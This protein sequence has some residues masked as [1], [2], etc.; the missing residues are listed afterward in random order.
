MADPERAAWLRSASRDWLSCDLSPRQ[1]CDLE[2]LLTGGFSPLTGFM[3]RTEHETVC[4]SMRLGTGQPWPWP[5]T[6]DVPATLGARLVPGA[7]LALRDPEDVMLAALHVEDVWT[8]DLEEESR[9]LRGGAERTGKAPAGSDVRHATHVGGRIEGL[10]LPAHYDYVELRRR[11]SD[12][13]AELAGRGWTGVAGCQPAGAMH[14]ADVASTCL[15]AADPDNGNGHVMVQL[16]TEG[17]APA[18]PRHHSMVRCLMAAVAAYPPG[19]ALLTIVPFA[20]REAGPREALLRAIVARNYGAATLL[21]DETAVDAIDA[22]PS[23]LPAGQSFEHEA[24]AIGVR[25]VRLPAMRYDVAR[26]SHVASPGAD[27]GPKVEASELA[28]RLDAGLPLPDWFTYPAVAA[29]L[30][31]LH[32]PRVRQGFTVFFTGLSGSGKSTIANV[33]LVRL[34]QAGGDRRA[35]LLDGDVV[36]HHLSSELGFSKAHRDL[37]VRR[38]GYVASEITKAGG[39]AICAPIAPYDAPRRDVRQMIAPLGGFVLVHVATPLDVC[40][41][42]DRKGLYTKARAGLLTHFTGI[43]DPYEAPA[44]ADVVIDTRVLSALEAADAIMTFLH[45]RHYIGGRPAGDPPGPA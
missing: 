18:D 4:Q 30:A 3:T 25:P 15:A 40:E 1:L 8:V 42:R 23:R 5:I 32:R 17:W 20:R 39:I 28:D 10:Q 41:Q 19:S 36:R 9:L 43:S 29:E 31:A 44:D 26:A 24:Q 21:L 14:R 35:T 11:P 27:A 7:M 38:I 22:G 33:L 37:N 16:L 45:Q 2:L 34:L 13:R 6:L 12:L